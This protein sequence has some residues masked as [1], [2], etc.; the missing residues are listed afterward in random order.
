MIPSLIDLINFQFPADQRERIDFMNLEKLSWFDL[1]LIYQDYRSENL[2][3]KIVQD[4]DWSHFQVNR[5]MKHDVINLDLIRSRLINL[6]INQLAQE[7]RTV[8]FLEPRYTNLV[9]EIIELRLNEL[10]QG[11]LS[12]YWFNQFINDHL[13]LFKVVGHIIG[14]QSKKAKNIPCLC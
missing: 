7:C 12:H 13:C 10:I 1:V 11:Q 3:L 14:P 8:W 2:R 5:M 9:F 6:E 4:S